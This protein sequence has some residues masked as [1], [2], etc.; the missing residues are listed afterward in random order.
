MDLGLT[1][2]HRAKLCLIPTEQVV[3]Q[4]L[5]GNMLIA[6]KFLKICGETDFAEL[7]MLLKAGMEEHNKCIRGNFYEYLIKDTCASQPILCF[8]AGDVNV[9]RVQRAADKD[10]EVPME[11]S[12]AKEQVL[13]LLA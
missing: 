9:W 8:C 10:K 13:P 5:P 7:G 6:L 11:R 12:H 1:W 4:H 3:L 2:A